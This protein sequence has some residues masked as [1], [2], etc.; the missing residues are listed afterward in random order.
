MAKGPQAPDPYQTANAQ[1]GQNAM[2]SMW[3]AAA[4]PNQFSP[5]GSQVN[6]QT[7][8]Q[9]IVNP[10]TGQQMQAPK[11]SS[12]ITLSPQEQ[13]LLNKNWALRGSLADTAVAQAG[14]IGKLL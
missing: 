10:M 5:Y 13:S 1:W 8:W 6:T 9:T 2:A 3:N 4:Q 12:T 11:Y 14:R 7:G